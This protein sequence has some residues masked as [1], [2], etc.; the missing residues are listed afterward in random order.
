MMVLTGARSPDANTDVVADWALA[1]TLV[2]IRVRAAKAIGK[3]L[4]LI[5]ILL[6]D[7][8]R[9]KAIIGVLNALR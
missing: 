9:I 1:F 6:S 7:L 2:S 5:K 8:D 4:L 3:D